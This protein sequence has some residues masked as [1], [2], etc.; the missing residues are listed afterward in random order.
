LTN[1]NYCYELA[2]LPA[3][4]RKVGKRIQVYLQTFIFP[5]LISPDLG[6][7]KEKNDLEIKMETDIQGLVFA[8]IR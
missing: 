2:S 5:V 7:P 8:F 6:H 1:K 3:L 4:E